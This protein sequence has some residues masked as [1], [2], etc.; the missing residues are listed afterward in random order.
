MADLPILSS[1]SGKLSVP[2]TAFEYYS[3]EYEVIPSPTEEVELETA[4]KALVQ[5]IKVPKIPYYKVG[6]PSGGD[7]IY[8]GSE[9][10]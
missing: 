4:N 8:I 9:V 2:T 7:T 6:N 1:L 10:V 5:N 3:G